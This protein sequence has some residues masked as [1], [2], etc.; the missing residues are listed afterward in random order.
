MCRLSTSSWCVMTQA[1]HWRHQVRGETAGPGTHRPTLPAAGQKELCTQQGGERNI[2][3][4]ASFGSFVLLWLQ[5]KF[6][7]QAGP[8]VLVKPYLGY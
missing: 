4:I 2:N 6:S 7:F 8:P 3:Q 5:E 1:P